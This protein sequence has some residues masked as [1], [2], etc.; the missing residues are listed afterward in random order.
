MIF[1]KEEIIKRE[2]DFLKNER[3]LINKI[4]NKI[5]L[6]SENKNDENKSKD[7]SH[8]KTIS[9]I[10]IFFY[11]VM[12]L[13]YLFNHIKYKQA[14]ITDDDIINTIFEMLFRDDTE[15]L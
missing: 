8:L 3:N 7:Y 14:N 2:K 13:R 9:V 4:I 15:K 11:G 12:K 10:R 5:K 1:K 6:L